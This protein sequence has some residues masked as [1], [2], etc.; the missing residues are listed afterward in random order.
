MIFL[1]WTQQRYDIMDDDE[2]KQS[3]GG[4]REEKMK[5]ADFSVADLLGERVYF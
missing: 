2:T 1:L 4:E 3:V 5:G